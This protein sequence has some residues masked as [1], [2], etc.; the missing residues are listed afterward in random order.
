MLLAMLT[1]L[2]THQ[3]VTSGE[4][5]A[6]R[7]R[8]GLRHLPRR[9]RHSPPAAARASAPPPRPPDRRPATAEPPPRPPRPPRDHPDRRARGVAPRPPPAP[10]LEEGASSFVDPGRCSPRHD[11]ALV[12][13]HLNADCA[14]SLARLVEAV[15]D[16]AR[17]VCSWDAA[18]RST[19]VPRHLRPAGRPPNL[20]LERPSPPD[21]HRPRSRAF[22]ARRTQNPVL[23]LLGDRSPRLRVDS[24]RL[25]LEDV[26]VSACASSGG[27]PCAS[28]RL[29]HSLTCAITMA[30]PG[31]VKLTS[32]PCVLADRGCPTG[33]AWASFPSGD[34]GRCGVLVE[35]SEKFFF[36]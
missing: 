15:F 30:R 17:S 7:P 18:R 9:D 13:Q 21:P 5:P 20:D 27:G 3:R 19:S 22:I 24:G 1:R 16:S 35:V 2:P 4:P 14:R 25:N 6:R 29:P 10:A 28:R 36:R 31:R 11:L 12:D 26:T 32:T 33:P 8:H 34:V 23:E